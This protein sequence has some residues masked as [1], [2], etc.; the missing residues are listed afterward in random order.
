MHP[1]TR[2]ALA[3]GVLLA[4]AGPV[5]AA[6][7]GPYNT[8]VDNAG[9]PLAS[10]AVDPHYQIVSPSVFGPGYAFHD[11]DGAPLGGPPA[12]AWLTDGLAGASS[13]ITPS[14]A[15]YI[16]DAPDGSTDRITYRTTFDLSAYSAPAWQIVGRWAADDGG[17]AIRLNGM[18]LSGFTVPDATGWQAFTITQGILPG[19]NVLEF[20]TLSTQSPTGLRVEMLTSAVPEPATG[21]LWLAGLGCAG[22]LRAR[23]RV[24]IDATSPTEDRA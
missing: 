23:R 1:I 3:L 20:D 19:V 21:L 15:L 17:V 10:Y 4:A 6:R 12:G 2:A 24:S 18:A 11:A 22:W 5:L 13:W 16:T 14:A 9:A 7:P 8:G